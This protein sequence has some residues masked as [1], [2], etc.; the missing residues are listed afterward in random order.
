MVKRGKKQRG[1]EP[2]DTNMMFLVGLVID[3][4]LCV[5]REDNVCRM[6]RLRESLANWTCHQVLLKFSTPNLKFYYRVNSKA[7]PATL[8]ACL[9]R[10]CL[11]L[12]M[13]CFTA[14][15][16]YD[17]LVTPIPAFPNM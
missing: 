10:K 6:F 1:R 4:R 11:P 13:V 12:I 7:Y 3:L 5:S 14:C 16:S 9:H 8:H 15:T 2:V 17:K